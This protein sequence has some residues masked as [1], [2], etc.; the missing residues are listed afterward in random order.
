MFSSTSWGRRR[1]SLISITF[2]LHLCRMTENFFRQKPL[3]TASFFH[4]SISRDFLASEFKKS[5]AAVP[6]L[7]KCSNTRGVED[8]EEVSGRTCAWYL[9]LFRSSLRAAAEPP[10]CDAFLR[11]SHLSV[12]LSVCLS[13]QPSRVIFRTVV[14][15]LSRGFPL[16]LL[17]GSSFLF[18][19]CCRVLLSAE[20]SLSNNQQRLYLPEIYG[21]P[22]GAVNSVGEATSSLKEEV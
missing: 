19:E 18:Q 21:V 1:D 13:V 5:I 11:A 22:L 17:D 10:S 7:P 8:N 12:C 14:S 4:P 16:M 15:L 20:G 3:K 6:H 9:T 2:A